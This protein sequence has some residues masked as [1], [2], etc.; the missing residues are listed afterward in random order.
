VR[1]GR[2]VKREIKREKEKKKKIIT[3]QNTKKEG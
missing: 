2:E 1:G 3:N